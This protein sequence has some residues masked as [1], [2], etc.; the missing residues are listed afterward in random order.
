MQKKYFLLLSS[1]PLCLSAGTLGKHINFQ[2]FTGVINTPTAEVIDDGEVTFSFA[3]QVD[4]FRIRHERDKYTAEH[5]FVNFGLLPNLEVIGRLANIEDKGASDRA[6]LDRD[7]SASFKYQLPLYHRYL[8]HIAV[9]A[10]DI[11]GAG[12]RY[13]SQ[14]VVLS[15][16][17]MFLQGSVGY[18]FG[19]GNLDG[20]FG[21]VQVKATDWLYLLS[22]Y[23]TQ[24]SRVGIRLTTPQKLFDRVAL[25]FTANKNLSD[26]KE[27]VSLSL[28][29]QIALGDRH[30]NI[31]K[32]PAHQT[33]KSI[34]ALLPHASEVEEVVVVPKR[35]RLTPSEMQSRLGAFRDALIRFGFENLD[36]GRRGERMYVAYENHVLDHNEVDAIGV[37]LGYMLKY[38]LPF[39]DFELVMK[40]SNQ[41]IRRIR[42]SLVLYKAFIESL[43][44]KSL[45]DFKYSLEMDAATNDDTPLQLYAENA[46]SSYLKTRVELS[47]GLKTFVATEVG[48][49]DYLVSLRPYV[50]W[51]LYRGFDLGVLTDIPLFKSDNFDKGGPFAPFDEGTKVKSVMLHRSDT[52]G[53]FLNIA[54][55]GMYDDYLGGFD[56]MAYTARNHTFGLKV[57]YLQDDTQ[58]VDERT[59]YLGSYTYYDAT[60]DA[61]LTLSGGKYYNQDTGFDVK[62][63]R[64]FGDTAITLFY[65][66]TSSEYMGV[67]VELPLTPRRV[68]DG[69]VQLKGKSDFS[70]SIR[71][72]IRDTSGENMIKPSGAV[73][74]ALEYSLESRMLNRNRLSQAY[75]R[76]HVLR[77]RDAY[78][79]YVAKEQ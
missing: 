63:K 7:L 40:K 69:Y 61:M 66:N 37:I 1:I 50:H 20:V 30:E 9:G 14:F 53:N 65:Q 77:L 45:R 27:K 33:E 51:N 34:E 70:Y 36:I 25:A 56:E 6:F 75:L 16:E 15:Q 52:A 60:Y 10:Q 8:P 72:S 73:N 32:V 54:S 68:P 2:G 28:S 76:A 55:A 64:F 42:G 5:Y 22:E 31:E 44:Q 4:A 17:Y 43:S 13:R 58:A 19:S 21:G 71:S 79:E 35:Q 29:F 18:G 78:I 48:V 12:D 47:P 49:F 74:P 24:D 23:D 46:N 11:S 41:P 26:T 67:G 57:G 59:V 3:N 62:F 38:D 39:E